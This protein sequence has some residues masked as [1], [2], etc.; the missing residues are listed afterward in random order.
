MD[1]YAEHNRL[2]E[3][4]LRLGTIAQVQARPP[5]VRVQSGQLTTDWRPWF[6]VRAG[7]TS[8]WNPPS[9]GE[10]C[11]LLCC[12]GDPATGFVLLGIP[13]DQ[14]PPPS[15]SLDEHVRRY[16]DGATITYNHATGALSAVGIRTALLQAADKVTVDCPL[17]ELTGDVHIMG[18]LTV[19]GEALI[20]SL[21]TYMSGMA[22]KS[23]NGAKTVIETDIEH[24]GSFH[25]S[26]GDFTSDTILQDNHRHQDS[27]GGMTSGP[28]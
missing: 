18:N 11:L 19:D 4:L 1:E 25:H 27:Q 3:S 14:F 17:T 16:P 21:L 24:K 9:V 5:R 28:K 12:S 26:S 7:T 8:E 13:S 20:N 6:T 2:I 15:A 23:G 22:G 10:Q